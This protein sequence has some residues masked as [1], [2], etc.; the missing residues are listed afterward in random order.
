[1]H[2]V[3]Q[4]CV[5]QSTYQLEY[6]HYRSSPCHQPIG[7]YELRVA[8]FSISMHACGSVRIVMVLQLFRPPELH[9][10]PFQHNAFSQSSFEKKIE[11]TTSNPSSTYMTYP[12]NHDFG[13][14]STF[15]M[16]W[17]CQNFKRFSQ[18]PSAHKKKF[19]RHLRLVAGF[20]TDFCFPISVTSCGYHITSTSVKLT[21]LKRRF[22]NIPENVCMSLFKVKKL[23]AHS[24]YNGQA[25][26]GLIKSVSLFIDC[27]EC[28]GNL[29]E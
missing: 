23:V 20:V 21:M 17:V 15:K 19:Y 11:C 18:T 5:P 14:S 2:T 9:Y 4:G 12:V 16:Y 24:M 29:I 26:T 8:W 1:M 3:N 7:D 13:P 25:L 6:G 22:Y 10:N 27:V 28:C